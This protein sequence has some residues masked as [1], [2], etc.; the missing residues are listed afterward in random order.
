[1]TR[2]KQE[3]E[4]LVALADKAR[5]EAPKLP[6]EDARRLQA[7]WDADAESMIAS[8]VED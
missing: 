4:R 1:M 5:E 6:A 8:M 7:K 2:S 3:I